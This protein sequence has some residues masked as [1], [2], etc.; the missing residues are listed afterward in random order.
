MT[1]T[2]M[3]ES[4]IPARELSFRGKVRDIY[5][6]GYELL[7]VTTDRISA[8]D[9]I[10][11][12]AIPGKGAILN[13][14]S[15]FW[16]EMF[17]DIVD[18]HVSHLDIEDVLKDQALAKDLKSRSV[19][20]RKADALPVECVVRGYLIGSGWKDYQATGQVCGV[21]LPKGL[22]LAEKL[23]EP[24]F[25]PAT[26]AEQGDHDENIDFDHV[27]KL[28]GEKKANRVKEISIQMYNKA[29][30]YAEERGIII[31][32]TKFEFGLLDDEVVLID[33]VLTPDSSR[34]WS[35]ENYQI[36]SSPDSYDKQIVRDY[37]EGLTWDKTA[38]A[39]ELPTEIIE[40]TASKYQEIYELLT[41][42]KPQF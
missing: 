29:A 5:D 18:N 26:K 1:V 12:E 25:T 10:M 8:F 4:H 16:M 6:L 36:G 37:L 17:Q 9:V 21:E 31:A 42:R 3:K 28:I 30:R 7:I 34:F 38:P 20:A 2:A 15:L 19:V 39:P 22:R 41:A 27:V 35:K 14:L 11:N 24:I 40:K 32:D 33:E 23:P 13:Q